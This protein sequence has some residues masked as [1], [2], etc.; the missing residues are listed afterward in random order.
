M[1]YS[2]EQWQ[3]A[4]GFFEAGKPL[5][6][7]ALETGISKASISAKSK[8]DGWEKGKTE[9]ITERLKADIIGT[10]YK[11]EQNAKKT[12]QIT[13]QISGLEDYQIHVLKHLVEDTTKSKSIIFSGLN[14][15]AI[16]A[17]QVLQ[18]NR[19]TEMIKVKEGFGNGVSQESFQT[20]ESDLNANDIKMH[21]E[22]L[23]K[24]GQGLGLIE[25]DGSSLTVNTQN[26]LQQNQAVEIDWD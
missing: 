24:A 6:Y 18:K 26:N 21:T 7:I 12:E 22:T 9:Q 19:K 25:K 13:E 16:R 15:A 17:T 11:T 10:D 4:K 20:V 1:A 8:S 23:I 5:A 14:M 2:K 3:K